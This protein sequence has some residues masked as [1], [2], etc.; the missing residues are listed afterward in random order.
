LVTC[1]AALGR[2]DELRTHVRGAVTKGVSREE[3][4]EFIPPAS[5]YCGLPVALESPRTAKQVLDE[6]GV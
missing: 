4:R 6:L 2:H 1:I 3:I 5:V